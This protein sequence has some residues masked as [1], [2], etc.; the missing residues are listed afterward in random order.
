[1]KIETNTTTMAKEPVFGQIFSSVEEAVKLL[2]LDKRHKWEEWSGTLSY[3]HWY[4]APCS[5]CNCDCSDGHGCNHGNSGCHECGYTGKRRSAV[6]VP[7]F[8][9]DGSIVKIVSQKGI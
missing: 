9:P 4:T 1:M 6:P 3:P 5:G 7:A 2:K 8:M